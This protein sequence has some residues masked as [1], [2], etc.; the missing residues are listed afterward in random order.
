[1]ARRAPCETGEVDDESLSRL[2]AVTGPAGS[3]NIPLAA[4]VASV[5]NAAAGSCS[6]ILVEGRSDQ[7]AIEALAARR[8]RNLG[9]EGVFVVPMGG[10][11]NVGSFLDLFGRRGLRARL[12][13]LCDEGEEHVFRHGLARAGLHPGPARRDLER[14][15]FYV[16]VAD[17]EDEMIR[18]LGAAS[19]E[20][21]IVGQGELASFRTFCRQPAQ[22]DRT[23]EQQLRRFLG[24]RSGRKIHYGQVLAEALDLTRVPR[25]LDRVLAHV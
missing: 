3:S 19:V 7:S 16:C 17:L 10:A 18:S 21:L 9:R 5:R 8:G 14:L 12:A 24:T 13:G 23:R 20:R 2:V 25:P 11:T 1:V 4:A 15:G 6:V 22:R